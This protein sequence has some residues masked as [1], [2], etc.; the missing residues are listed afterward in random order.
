MATLYTHKDENV[1]K[2]WV[3]MSAFF[4]VVIAVGW[5]VSWYYHNPG[6]LIVAVILN[7][8]SK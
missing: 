7:G 2:T 1:A 3:L 8:K 4:A 6:I 5:A